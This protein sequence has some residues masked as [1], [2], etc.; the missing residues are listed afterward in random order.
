M[1]AALLTH[2]LKTGAAALGVLNYASKATEMRTKWGEHTMES[3][4][5]HEE[6]LWCLLSPTSTPALRALRQS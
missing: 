6:T 1:R 3:W 4:N 5:R 2:G